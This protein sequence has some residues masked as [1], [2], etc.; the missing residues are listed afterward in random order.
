MFVNK[1]V[2]LIYRSPSPVV[3]QYLLRARSLALVM[4]IGNTYSEALWAQTHAAPS[5]SGNPSGLTDR[6]AEMRSNSVVWDQERWRPWVVELK[7]EDIT[8]VAGYNARLG[9]NVRLTSAD[10]VEPRRTPYGFITIADSLNWTVAVPSTA[11]YQ[12]AVLYHSGVQDNTGSKLLVSS[13]NGS[14]TALV[15]RVKKGV[16]QG[17]PQDRPSFRR[18]WL[19]GSLRLNKGVNELKLSV[20]PTARQREFGEADLRKPLTGWPKRSLHV[21]AIEIVRPAVLSKMRRDA[22]RMKSS[23]QWM[24]QGK[25]GIMIHW[26]PES[27]SFHGDTPAWKHYQQAVNQFDVEAFADMVAKTG[28]AWVVFTTTHGKYFFPGPLHALDAVLPGRTCHRDLIGEIADALKK[29]HIRLMLYFHP[30]PGPTEDSEWA[31]AAGISPLD[32]PKNIDIMLSIYREIGHRYGTRLAG[33][34]ID[35]GSAYYWR[36]F[37]FRQLLIALKTE[38]PSRVVTFF[39]WIFPTFSPYAGDFTSDLVDFGAPL[40]PPFPRDW[41]LAGGPYQGL[42]P[43]FNFTLEDEWY[44]EKPMHGEWPRTIYA[45]TVL[46]DYCKR[47]ARAKVPLSIN[48]V[49]TQDVTSHQPFVSPASLEEMATVRKAIRGH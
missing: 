4:V 34:F 6:D 27:Y 30:G 36:N 49:I 13:G 5:S 31:R 40:A 20:I 35:G 23:T 33:W 18:A 48:I 38:N 3:K 24:V 47:M 12:I 19:P 9:G 8:H 14:V 21:F 43:Q 37:S 44:P 11:N 10:D 22:P 39:Q 32:D 42:L 7:P 26:V 25:Y 29:R 17:G 28:A 15:A 41:K 45:T 16:W 2:S 1:I 46:A